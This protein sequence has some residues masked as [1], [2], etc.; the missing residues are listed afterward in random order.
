MQ[1]GIFQHTTSHVVD[2]TFSL[3]VSAA[4][5]SFCTHTAFVFWEFA[6]RRSEVV[7]SWMQPS[8]AAV[9]SRVAAGVFAAHASG[10]SAWGDP[11]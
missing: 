4:G 5:A 2:P 7:K 1:H 3:W 11:A 10:A 9:A 6:E 8:G